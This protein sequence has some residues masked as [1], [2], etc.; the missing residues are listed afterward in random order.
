MSTC[1]TRRRLS[2][3]LL[4]AAAL[5]SACTHLDHGQD[6]RREVLMP[7]RVE[8]EAVS[9]Y[10]QEAYQCGPAAMAMVLDWTGLALRPE[11]LVR[12]VY[13]PSRQGSLQT[14]MISAARRHGRLAYAFNGVKQLLGEVAAG[15]PVIVLQN[16]GTGWY[17]VWHYAVV[18]GF[19]RTA[20]A[21]ILHTGT[22]Q[23]REDAWSRFLFTWERGQYWGLLVLP[24]GKLPAGTDETAYLRAV[25]GLEQARQWDAAARAYDAALQR[26]P[27]S[28]GALVGLGN[29]HIA[30]GDL[31]AAEHALRRAAA[32]APDSGDAANNLAHVLGRRGRRD[33]ALVWARRAVKNGGPNQAI[34]RQTLQ[35]IEAL[36][37]P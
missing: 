33:E 37:Q 22:D 27:G 13:T 14:G 6:L 20:D 3:L 11:D 2:V 26:W 24:P 19:D 10:P 4:L 25:L 28:L 23:G 7:E 15:H 36:P 1:P 8:I 35:E 21:V 30:L 5:T 12:E 18:V 32:A 9:F 17:P 31:A 16:L 34:Y 29:C